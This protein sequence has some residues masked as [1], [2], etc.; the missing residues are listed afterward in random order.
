MDNMNKEDTETCGDVIC[1]M[2]NFVRRQQNDPD[3]HDPKNPSDLWPVMES[4]LKLITG[5]ANRFENA[6]KRLHVRLRDNIQKNCL[7]GSTHALRVAVQNIRSEL[8][9]TGMGPTSVFEARVDAITSEALEIPIR[10]VDRFADLKTAW[11]YWVKETQPAEFVEYLTSV[12]GEE[13]I[14]DLYEPTRYQ[15]FKFVNWLFEPW[16]GN[17]KNASTMQ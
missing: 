9:K 1:G 16:E 14:S 12:N 2:R 13:I 4:Y 7:T 15:Y 10:N 11:M 17:T 6:L 8:M 3:Y 5:Y